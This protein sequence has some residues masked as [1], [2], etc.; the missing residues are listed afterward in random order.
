[1]TDLGQRGV[2][3][4]FAMFED[5]AF[6]IGAADHERSLAD[7]WKHRVAVTVLEERGALARMFEHV[8][9]RAVVVVTGGGCNSG[10]Q[11]QCAGHPEL[12]DRIHG[13]SPVVSGSYPGLR[14]GR[15]LR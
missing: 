6:A 8:D 11:Q 3:H 14:M 2:S 9:G 15:S 5:A 7:G 4:P 10:C 12:A 1:D 13:R